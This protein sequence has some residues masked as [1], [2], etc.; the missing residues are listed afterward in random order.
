VSL[1]ERLS[2]SLTMGIAAFGN[3]LHERLSFSQRS[4]IGGSTVVV[5]MLAVYTCIYM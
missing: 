3:V 5:N 2:S 1:V 4:F